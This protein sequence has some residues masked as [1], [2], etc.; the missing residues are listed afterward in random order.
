M[1]SARAIGADA[2]INVKY[3]SGIGFM[4]WGYIDAEGEGVRLIN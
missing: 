3:T 4:T 1:K 2:V